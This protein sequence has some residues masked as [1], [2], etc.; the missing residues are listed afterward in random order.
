MVSLLRRN[1]AR[2]V[3]K[4][5]PRRADL[6]TWPVAPPNYVLLPFRRAEEE[7]RGGFADRRKIRRIVGRHPA[8]ATR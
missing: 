2:R 1:M 8:D 7:Q 6:L 5:K 4:V 3:V